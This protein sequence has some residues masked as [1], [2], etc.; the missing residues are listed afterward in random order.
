MKKKIHFYVIILLIP[1]TLLISISFSDGSLSGLTGSPGDGGTSCIGCHTATAPPVN[2][3]ATVDI[4][5]NISR[6]GYALGESY[7]ITVMQNATGVT[8]HGFQITA[9]D[10]TGTFVG[11]FTITDAI[12]TQL[13]TGAGSEHVS[14]TG[15][16]DGNG[17]LIGGINQSSWT[18]TWTAPSSDMGAITFY[19]ASVAANGNGNVNGDQ[20]VFATKIIGN[21]LA[22]K[23]AQLLD[24]SMYP[25][26]TEE[27]V[28]LQLPSGANK[29]NVK[30]FDYLGKTL[31]QRDLNN[32][33]TNLDISKLSSGIYFVRIQSDAKVGT[34]KLIIH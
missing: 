15:F 12:N 20:V 26:P 10:N 3:N 7:T 27:Q 9:E 32:S 2:F 14:H 11:S 24:F 13:L 31:I 1:T 21:V 17:G 23:K 22:V 4:T 6:N 33:N 8:E 18:F 34:K 28:N 25:N 16:S 5:T 30:I 19:V 29:G